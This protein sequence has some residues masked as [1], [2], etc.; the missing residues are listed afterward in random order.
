[1][2]LVKQEMCTLPSIRCHPSSEFQCRSYSGLLTTIY[3][4]I[5]LIIVPY[6][7]RF[8]ASNY[9]FGIFTL[10]ITKE[11]NVVNFNFNSHVQFCHFRI[12]NVKILNNRVKYFIFWH[13]Y[14]LISVTISAYKRCSVR[15]YLELFVGG[16]MPYLRYLCLFTHSGVQHILCCVFVLISSSCV[17]YVASF[18]G[19]PFFDCPF[20]IL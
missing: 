19:L 4:F 3:P 2:P 7:L 11:L 16:R 14:T 5:P 10:F 17:P 1:M 6:V 18:S 9:S 20:G 12:A 13:C 15:L 8:T